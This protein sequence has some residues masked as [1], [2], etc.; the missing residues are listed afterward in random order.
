VTNERDLLFV[1]ALV[2]G[3][4]LGAEGSARAIEIDRFDVAILVNPDSTLLV[5]ETIEVDFG[6][7]QKHGIF[8]TIP[9][10][11]GRTE[12]FTGVPIATRYSIRLRVLA[13]RNEADQAHPYTVSHQGRDLFLRIGDPYRTVTGRVTYVITYQVQRAVNRFEDHDEIYWNVTG[14]EWEW[15]IKEA[16]VWVMLP[17]GMAQAEAQVR[18]RTFTG[19]MGSTTTSATETLEGTSYH[20][21]VRDLGPSEG[22]TVVLGLPKGALRTPSAAQELWWKVSDN[23][24]FLLA[25]LLPLSSL[26]L[27][28]CLYLATGRDPGRKMPIVVQY[29]PPPDLSPAE[30][31]SLVDERI[32]TPDIVSTVL[33]LAVRGYLKIEEIETK[34]FLFLTQKDYAFEKKRPADEGLSRHEK[35]F[36]DALFASGDRVLLSSLKYKFY[37]SIP[38]VRTAIA[39]QML[40][41]DLFPRDPER[42]RQFF[43]KVGCTSVLLSVMLGIT[44]LSLGSPRLMLPPD[45]M[46]FFLFALSCVGLTVLLFWFFSRVMPRKTPKGARLARHC[47]G[48]KEFIER[49]EKDRL[50]RMA[51]EDPTL[52][53]RVLPYAVVLGVADEW[54]ERFEGLLTEPPSWYESP[55]FGAGTFVPSAMVSGIGQSMHAMG[56]TLTSQPSSSGSTS[57]ASGGGGGFS[58]FGGGGSSGGGFGGGGGGSW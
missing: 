41:K 28:T 46:A 2:F 10:D 36:F 58:G 29:E 57:W 9:V 19:R 56:S 37:L 50:E 27:L 43:R 49:V 31:G 30:V 33:D 47:L 8:R 24:A 55:S 34:M 51:K 17:E 20:V 5:T 39:Q 52:F 1:A 25:A 38:R 40:D 44:L 21:N 22:L 48:F 15:P 16:G 42:V 4:V 6:N 53:E 18:H 14:T 35:A 11:Y 7:L 3:A 54:A 32:D 13:V 23:V 45:P 12:I 26:V